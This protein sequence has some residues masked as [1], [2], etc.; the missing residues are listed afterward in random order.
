MG[1]DQESVIE[2]DDTEVRLSP[3]GALGGAALILD[4]IVQF[5][6]IITKIYRAIQCH[7]H[8]YLVV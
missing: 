5:K 8:W 6:T 2:C 4:G 1:S 7:T 3:V